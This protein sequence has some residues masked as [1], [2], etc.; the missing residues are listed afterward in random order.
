MSALTVRPIAHAYGD[1]R[2]RI[3]AALESGVEWIE[4]DLRWWGGKTWVRHEHR[5]PGLPVL[6]N[7]N[8]QGI[9]RAGPLGRS[10]GPYWLRLDTGR[11]R[12][13]EL[14]DRTSGRAS[15]M[16]DFKA[17]RYSRAES[18]RFVASVLRTLE[19]RPFAGGIDF[20]GMWGLL[21]LVRVFRP[22]QEVHYS[23]DAPRD[24]GLVQPRLAANDPAVGI[25]IRRSLLT[26]ARAA[27]L[28]AANTSFFAWDI[29][30]AVQA[31]VAI[32]EGAGGILA[33]DLDLLRSLAGRS[34]HTAGPA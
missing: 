33:D 3:E 14:L 8:L 16:L 19:L 26:P 30:E 15:L 22:A 23:V 24:W 17:Q 25:S 18:R 4:A 13:E 9:H 29:D 32:A 1:R 34:I 7:R 5:L 12:F 10:F 27:Q 28:R 20:C 2:R 21:D 11:M 6:W 31:E